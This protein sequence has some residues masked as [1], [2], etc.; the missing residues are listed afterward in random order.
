[1][2]QS[3]RFGD[4]N[5][6]YGKKHTIESKRLMSKPKMSEKYGKDRIGTSLYTNGTKRKFLKPYEVTEEWIKVASKTAKI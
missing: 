5:P 6:M 2:F 4:L 3:A 1:M